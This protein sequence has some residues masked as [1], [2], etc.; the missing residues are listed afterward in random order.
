MTTKCTCQIF[1]FS[2]YLCRHILKIFIVVDVQSLPEQYI[3]KRWT[4]DAKSG[5]LVAKEG[6]TIQVDYEKSM[7]L[8]YNNLCCE[9]II[10]LLK[11]Q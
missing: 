11:L 4:K 6:G 1:E 5:N 3:L 8:R 9:E 7:T 2:S 10:F